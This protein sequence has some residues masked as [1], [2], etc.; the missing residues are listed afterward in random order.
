M[1]FVLIMSHQMSCIIFLY[2]KLK[3]YSIQSFK[4]CLFFVFCLFCILLLS[5]ST[6]HIMFYTYICCWN[7]F[8]YKYIIQITSHAV[9]Q[10][11]ARVTSKDICLL[12]IILFLCLLTF[13]LDFSFTH[14]TLFRMGG[15]K[16]VSPSHT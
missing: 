8:Q 14:L 7:T 6:L 1:L 16:K 10:S 15:G 11:H 4:D 9:K 13:C 2:E 5:N 12:F 3:S